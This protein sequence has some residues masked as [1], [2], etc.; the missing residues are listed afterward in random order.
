MAFKVDRRRRSSPASRSSSGAPS[1]T[2][3]GSPTSAISQYEA[4]NRVVSAATVE[5]R[6][7]RQADRAP[8]LREAA[9][10]G[11]LRRPTFEPSTEVGIRSDL[12]EDLYVVFAGSVDGTEEA[13]Y[14]F[15][16]NPL[17]WWVW[18]GGIVLAFGGLVTMWPGGGPTVAAP[19]A[20]AGRLRR[21]ARRGG[22]GVSDAR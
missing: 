4:L 22:N 9:A 8:H 14:R 17:V 6:E 11:Q 16:I 2:P 15:T 10:R 18:F 3:T 20:G 5:V 21:D 13:V 12:R 1:G 19:R 7:G